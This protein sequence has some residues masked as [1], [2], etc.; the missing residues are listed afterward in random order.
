VGKGIVD[1]DLAGG[2]DPLSVLLDLFNRGEQNFGRYPKGSSFEFSGYP[3]QEEAMVYRPNRA[4][5]FDDRL[6]GAYAA[7]GRGE[8]RRG[9]TRVGSAF[10]G[11]GIAQGLELPKK[12]AVPANLAASDDL[13]RALILLHETRVIIENKDYHDDPTYNSEIYENCFKD[14]K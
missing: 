8:H 3:R 2:G 14:A 4:L 13:T 9:Y 1:K 5:E 7:S 10:F 6:A 12:M 11:T